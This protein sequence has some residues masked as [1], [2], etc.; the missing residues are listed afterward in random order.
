MDR[1]PPRRS[2]SRAKARLSPPLHPLSHPPASPPR[3]SAGPQDA[4]GALR[5]YPG[6]APVVL[7]A[8]GRSVKSEGDKAGS[9]SGYEFSPPGGR[10]FRE[11][12]ARAYV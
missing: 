3:P 4:L 7:Q 6:C 8:S 10:V 1:Y 12:R 5:L 9:Q 2:A 11:H